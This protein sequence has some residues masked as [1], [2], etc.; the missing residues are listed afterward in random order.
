MRSI[1]CVVSSLFAV[2]VVGVTPAAAAPECNLVESGTTHDVT[3]IPAADGTYTLRERATSPSAVTTVTYLLPGL[4]CSFD[5]APMVANCF[6]GDYR[7]VVS[8]DSAVHWDVFFDS[9]IDW[10]RS[11][12][13]DGCKLN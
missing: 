11:F 13:A 9:S 6:V 1:V 2:A 12:V 10:S 3:L 8:S 4:T 5:E 7:L